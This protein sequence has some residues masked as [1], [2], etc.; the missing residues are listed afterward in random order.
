[1]LLQAA[2]SPLPGFLFPGF[3]KAKAALLTAFRE[4]I[5]SNVL[6]GTIAE[7]VYHSSGVWHSNPT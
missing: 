2:A 4:A 7:A 3:K 1:M 6:Q 5:D